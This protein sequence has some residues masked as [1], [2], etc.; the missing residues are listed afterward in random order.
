LQSYAFDPM[1][2]RLSGRRLEIDV[3]Y[4]TLRPGPL[5]DLIHVVD[6]D[7][8]R[9]TWYRPVDLDDPA[10][11]AGGG[12]R[13]VEAD[14]RTH[15]QVAYAVAMSVIER[16]ERFLGRR[17]RWREGQA[18][19]L[20]PH[21]FEG[22]NAFFDPTRRAVL[23]GYY[24]ADDRDPGPNLPGQVMFTC[25]SV[26]IVAHEVTH[27]LMHRIRPNFSIATNPDVFAWHEAFADL[28]A[29]FHHFVFP[30]V[31]SDAV[32]Q[33][34]GDLREGRGL[35]DL[36]QEFGQSTGRGQ[37]LRSAISDR[38]ATPERFRNATEPHER[39]ACFVAGVFDAYLATYQRNTADLLRIATG[40]TGVLPPGH[41]HPDLV[42]R[43]S[44]EAVKNADRFLGIVVRAFDFLPVVDVTFGDV[45]RAIVTADRALYPEDMGLLRSTLV[46]CLRR[47]GIYPERISSLADEALAWPAPTTTLQLGSMDL[48]EVIRSATQDLD[49]AG[50]PGEV[51]SVADSGTPE[52]EPNVT[53]STGT[54]SIAPQLL[55]W[56]KLNALELGLDP[57]APNTGLNGLHV[58]YQQAADGQPQPRLVM[59][60]IQRRRDLEDASVDENRRV[61]VRAG[62]TVVARVDGTV[63]RIIA[64]PLPLM[65]PPILDTAL[66]PVR[67]VAQAYHDLG[68]ERLDRLRSWSDEVAQSDPLAAWTST[69]AIS[70]LT[71]AQLHSLANDG[72]RP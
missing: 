23:F 29:L 1:S 37:A 72:P 34:R 58:V 3:R 9:D 7:G 65:H 71:F 38:D 24:R 14:P 30:E 66:P 59:Q 13:P 6:Y 63:D 27:A 49:T 46:E 4:E 56:A 40:G 60:F 21:A 57:D 35:L 15:Q 17:F 26:D 41:L 67:D 45:V 12:L 19:V 36:A 25:L 51:Q 53:S 16:F 64:K 42:E 28:V 5:G 48:S 50:L 10:I 54:S 47:R 44:G 20:V 2:T 68:S 8:T 70:R 43:V 55:A 33:S 11:L 22:R 32:A 62:T 61:P 69:P 18:L 39:G 52:E 31:V